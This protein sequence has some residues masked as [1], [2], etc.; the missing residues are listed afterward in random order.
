[1]FQSTAPCNWIGQWPAWKLASGKQILLL[2]ANLVG[3]AFLC[4]QACMTDVGWI[5]FVDIHMFQPTA[6]LK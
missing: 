6:E 3:Q 5:R 1:V 2:L 4:A